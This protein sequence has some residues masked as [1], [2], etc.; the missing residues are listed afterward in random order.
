MH[1]FQTLNTFKGGAM[2]D[3]Q[4]PDLQIVEPAQI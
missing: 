2:L 1:K 4:N 3:G